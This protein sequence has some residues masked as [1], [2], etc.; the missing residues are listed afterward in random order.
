MK[1]ASLLLTLVLISVV[2]TGCA[3]TGAFNAATL[4]NVGLSQANYVLVASNVTGEASAGYL[5]GVS[6]SVYREMQTIALVRVSGTG[7]LYGEALD[8]LWENFQAEYGEAEGRNL[9]L[10]N[11]RYDTEA[12]NL[13]VFTRPTVAVRADV[14]EFIE[15]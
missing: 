13:L 10:V 7:R 2:M 6:G 14:V 5:L 4:T 8:N 15:E 12:L 3:T 11:V 9:A 1:N